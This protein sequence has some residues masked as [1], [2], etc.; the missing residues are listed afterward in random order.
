MG[1]LE[2]DVRKLILERYRTLKSFA[3]AIEIPDRTL[4][5]ALSKGLKNTTFSTIIPICAALDIDPMD[6]ANEK[7]TYTSGARKPVFVPLYGSITASRP[8]VPDTAQDSFPLP[9]E[10]HAAYPKAFML[11]IKGNSMN[12]ILPNGYLALIDPCTTIDVSGQIYAVAIDGQEATVKR[13]LLHDNGLTL[14]PDSSDPTY[15]PKLYDYGVRDTPRV[16]AIGRVV[17]CCSPI[18]SASDGMFA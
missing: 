18:S 17:W 6:I 5:S 13:V 4:Y 12:R 16:S 10:L 9:A 15:K 2:D 7:L 11:R 8:E 1:Q 14:C 3:K